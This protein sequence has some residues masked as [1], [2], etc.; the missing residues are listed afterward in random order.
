MKPKHL[1]TVILLLFVVGSV[2]YMIAQERKASST[3]AGP[4]A[5]PPSTET[6]PSGRQIIVYYFH[7][8]VRCPTCHKLET[9]ARQAVQTGF[10]EEMKAGLVVWKAVNVDRP[11]NA[12]FVADYK[13]VTKAVILSEIID[14]K[15]TGWKN[16]DRIWDLVGD[17][18]AYLEYIRTNLQ[19][20]LE[21]ESS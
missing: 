18:P 12:H 13:L 14:G 20:F 17:E 9:F 3:P 2:A 10:A 21:K 7:G 6:A 1:I 19:N 8:D 16:L 11:E 5:A 15:E 4:A